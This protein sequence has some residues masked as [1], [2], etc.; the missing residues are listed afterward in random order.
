[1][2]RATSGPAAV[3]LMLFVL[4]GCG[5]GPKT[6]AVFGKVTLDNNVVNGGTVSFLSPGSGVPV[7]VAINMDGSYHADNVPV[8]DVVVTVNAAVAAEAGEVIKNRGA[9]K[10]APG[11]QAP[12][13]PPEG[14]VPKKYADPAASGL[15]TTAT[16]A[17]T[18]YDIR[19]SSQP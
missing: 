4:A 16:E 14:K 15:A 17:G 3:A 9:N 11:K 1:M 6:G 8:G 5:G 10:Q 2:T 19:L 13:A 18:Q 12:A 7:T